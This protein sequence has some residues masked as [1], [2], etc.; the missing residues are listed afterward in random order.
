M[1]HYLR[2]KEQIGT[3]DLT[4]WA[5]EMLLEEFPL[6]PSGLRIRLQW[7]RSLQRHRFLPR[8]GAAGE[9][10]GIAIAAG[11]DSIPGRGTSICRGCGHKNKRHKN[12]RNAPGASRL[13]ISLRNSLGRNGTQ[14]LH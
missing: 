11:L 13:I 12:K 8:P 9:P 14:Y 4:I 3:E 6:W 7:L 5:K 1:G 10:S 2:P